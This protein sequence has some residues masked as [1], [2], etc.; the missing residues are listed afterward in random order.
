MSRIDLDRLRVEFWEKRDYLTGFIQQFN[1]LSHLYSDDKLLAA[2]AR[3]YE[4]HSTILKDLYDYVEQ[5]YNENAELRK[6][7][8]QLKKK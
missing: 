5:L 6:E 1:K 3:M 7:I 8:E 4:S 2:S